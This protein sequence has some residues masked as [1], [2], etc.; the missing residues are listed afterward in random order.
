M[1]HMPDLDGACLAMVDVDN[2][3]APDDL[4]PQKV[5]GGGKQYRSERLSD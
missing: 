5:E 1:P 2:N 3:V 4:M